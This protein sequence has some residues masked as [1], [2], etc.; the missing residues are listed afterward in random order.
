MQ[1]SWNAVKCT[2]NSWWIY[3]I[4]LTM[5]K[6]WCF[7]VGAVYGGVKF[8]TGLSSDAGDLSS[9]DATMVPR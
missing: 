4:N 3:S 8:E 7:L 2:L 5:Q 1:H 6:L 9:E